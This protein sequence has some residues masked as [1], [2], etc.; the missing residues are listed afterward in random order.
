M[1]HS[2][3]MKQKLF[4]AV[5]ALTFLM[6]ATTAS[7]VEQRTGTS[8][9]HAKTGFPLL[10][11]HAQADCQTCHLQGIFKGT[12]Q[13]C[14]VCHTKGS[15]L[16]I[17]FKPA[18]HPKTTRQCSQCHTSTV[19][20]TG[21]RFDHIGV[22]T[23]SCA[24]CHNGSDATGKPIKHVV[25]TKPCDDCHRTTAWLPATFDHF[26]VAAGSCAT[27]HGVNATGK[28]NGHLV[29]SASCDTCHSTNAWKP[30]GV[31]HNNPAIVAPGQCITCHGITSTGQVA[32]HIP[33]NLS[34]DACHNKYPARFGPSTFTHSLA[35]G[36]APG[37]CGTC[38]SGFYAA[39]PSNAQGKSKPHI[40]TTLSCDACHSQSSGTFSGATFTHTT[41]QM[42]GNACNTCHSGA[43]AAAPINAQGLSKPHI[44]TGA[45][46]CDV[47][48]SSTI[49]FSGAA[50]TFTHTATQM[51]GGTCNTCHSGAYAAAPI[52]AQGLIS[53]HI[54]TGSLQCDACHTSFTAFSGANLTFTHLASQ[55]VVANQCATCHSGSY[56]A[57]P[58]NA[59][60][61]LQGHVSTSLSCDKC[62]SINAWKPAIVDHT[63]PAIVAPGQCATCH[64]V[65]ATGK[66]NG[67]V[68]TSSSC[69]ACHS[70]TVWKPAGI[71]HSAV[72]AGTCGTCHGISATGQ[73]S[74]HIPS[75]TMSCDVC[76]NKPPVAAHFGPAIFAHTGPQMSGNTCNTCHSGS[77]AAA[78][79]NA[80]G[81]SSPHIPIAA[82]LCDACHTTSKTT[83]S[84]AA[85]TFT[86]TGP[87]MT[88]N[89]CNTC[90]SGAYAAAPMNAQ[91]LSSPHIPTAGM[92]CSVCHTNTTTFSGAAATFT[93]T[94]Q[95]MS[96]G[97]C[98]TCH[99]GAYAAAPNNA[100]G[101]S[102]PHI[103]IG[104]YLCS[105]CHAN[106]TAFSGAAATF[107]HAANQGVSPG[108]C[109]TCHD[110]SYAAAPNNAYGM[111]S[112]SGYKHFP[113]ATGF[114]NCDACHGSYAAFT[115]YTSASWHQGVPLAT[116]T[117]CIT[118]HDGTH[119]YK[120]TH[121]I[122]WQK[123]HGSAPDSH[124]NKCHTSQTDWKQGVSATRPN[125]TV[126]KMPQFR[127][128]QPVRPSQPLL[129][130]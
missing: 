35:Q 67:H 109:L 8:F 4:A 82:L 40:P 123:G 37:L 31:D 112:T 3:T 11:A 104:A 21:A 19:T 60:G 55:G 65:T 74:G 127:S 59:S 90:H 32:G 6:F 45:L 107:T 121:D 56:A 61:K 103:P 57:A 27:C 77:Y 114:A 62:H 9:D 96:G 66:P 129:K 68:S 84:G 1:I 42:S 72:V 102:S 25:T 81:L 130:K 79:T 63:N 13:Q 124:C 117:V 95:Q 71:D 110:G 14:D 18:K 92:L 43:Y 26:G 53:P 83:F 94:V 41:E 58:M 12:P 88:G 93:H 51:S 10:G 111:N 52:N 48:H 70:T 29:T 49:A 97:T 120:S 28:P 86:H 98:N 101:L 44:P 118:C 128:P 50:A 126:T 85:A 69:D 47:C 125:G 80:Q 16:A 115:T 15:R 5:L 108:Q 17:T 23:G 2:I 78:P 89:T 24:Y 38:H 34:C 54:P 73:I 64:G 122:G 105:V 116:T 22:T 36:V 119:V 113:P 20:W 91:G 75:G 39:A 46:S 87:Q 99:S 7:A 106:T 30:A 76:H 100:Q 33:T